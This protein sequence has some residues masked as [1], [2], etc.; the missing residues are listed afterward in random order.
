VEVQQREYSVLMALDDYLSM[1]DVFLYGRFVRQ[2]LG[3]AP[4]RAF[5]KRV[6]ETARAR[7]GE[8]VEYASRYHLGIGRRP[9]AARLI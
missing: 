4:W 2:S 1:I 5:R 6:D 9:W 8:R 3:E 7:C